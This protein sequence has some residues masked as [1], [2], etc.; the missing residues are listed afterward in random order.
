MQEAG[1]RP[2]GRGLHEVDELAAVGARGA[3]LVDHQEV[4]MVGV[5]AERRFARDVQDLQ[6]KAADVGHPVAL[7]VRPAVRQAHQRAVSAGLGEQ[8]VPGVVWQAGE[9]LPASRWRPE[10]ACGAGRGPGRTFRPGALQAADDLGD[11][12]Q[13]RR[14]VGA[15]CSRHS[16]AR[17]FHVRLP[18]DRSTSA[19]G[20]WTS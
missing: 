19:G 1:Q 13:V 20:E 15:T 10:A 2:R 17:L 7:D 12:H 14:L 16:G 5:A 3:I 8:A 11:T 9:H 4:L 6:G 18:L